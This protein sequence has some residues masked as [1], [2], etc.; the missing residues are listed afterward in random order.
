MA[1]RRLDMGVTLITIETATEQQLADMIVGAKLPEGTVGR[2]YSGLV[3][4]AGTC[5][6]SSTDP[7]IRATPFQQKLYAKLV[8]AVKKARCPSDGRIR[9]GDLAMLSDAGKHGAAPAINRSPVAAC[10]PADIWP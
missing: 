9:S 5:C 8:N 2:H 3:F 7:D 1:K 4:D 6:E 10:R